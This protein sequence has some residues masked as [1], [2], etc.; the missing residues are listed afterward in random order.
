[1]NLIELDQGQ[2]ITMTIGTHKVSCTHFSWLHLPT[3]I[4]Q[5]TTVENVESEWPWTKVNEWPSP[6]IFNHLVNCIYPTLTSQTTIL[7]EKSIVLL[8]FPYKSIRDQIWP[9]HK[10]GLGQPRVII[11]TNLVVLEHPMLHTKFQSHS[12]SGEEEFFKVFTI[13]GHGGH[14][15]QVTRTIWTNFC[16][17]V[18]RRL[19]MKCG[20]NQPS[21]FRGD[22]WKWHTYTHMDDRGLP[23]L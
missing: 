13:Y 12:G 18:P 11:W 14:L 15:G 6:L 2:W 3:F 17:P 7:S 8:F 9:C 5:T 10:I 23:T 22:V 21:G 16:S 20:L 19:H 4:S 1:M